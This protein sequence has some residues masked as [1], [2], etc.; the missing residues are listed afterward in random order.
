MHDELG[1]VGGVRLHGDI[2]LGLGGVRFTSPK[3]L[4]PNIYIYMGMTLG[5]G[6]SML[7]LDNEP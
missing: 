1:L 5:L 3:S 7:F 2:G 4:V 6:K